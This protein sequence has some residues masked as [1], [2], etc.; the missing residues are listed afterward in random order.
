[1][2]PSFR[3]EPL[4]AT[5]F[6]LGEGPFRA[7]GLAYVAALRYVDKRIPGGRAAVTAALG[8]GDPWAPFYDQIF[9]V[10][11]E[12][13]ASPLLRLFEVCAQIEGVF[14]GRLIEQGSRW[15]AQQDA[16]GLWRAMLKG[17]SLEERAD[18]TRLAFNRYFPPCQAHQMALRPGRFEG[19]LSSLPA[20]MVGLYASAT[21]G[22]FAGALEYAG[23][24]DVRLDWGWPTPDGAIAGVPTERVRFTATWHAPAT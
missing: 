13:D 2:G 14:V 11:G 21:N 24:T 8:P 3:F 12:Y 16:K 15:S 9:L 4:R 7:R 19:E 18:R 10:S 23:A 6:P 20:P 17:A 22:F 5:A 1:M